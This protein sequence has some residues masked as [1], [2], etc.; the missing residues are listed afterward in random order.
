MAGGI[1]FT[2]YVLI[3]VGSMHA[4]GM[5][6]NKN[7]LVS[8]SSS[9]GLSLVPSMMVVVVYTAMSLVMVCSFPLNAFGLRVGLHGMFFDGVETTTQRWLGSAA[10][11]S[12]SLLVALLVNDL[13]ALFR[14]TGATTSMYIMFLL[15][16][17]LILKLAGQPVPAKPGYQPPSKQGPPIASMQTSRAVINQ[18]PKAPSMLGAIILLVAGIVLGVCGTLSVFIV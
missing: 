18:Q 16:S 1:C 13:G 2:L 11:I 15:P 6:V 5:D 9:R 3:A 7:V 14:I 10:L 17:S 12:S 8:L 4:F